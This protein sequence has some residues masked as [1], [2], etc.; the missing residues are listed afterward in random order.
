VSLLGPAEKGYRYVLSDRI[1]KSNVEYLDKSWD[2]AIIVFATLSG[3][4]AMLHVIEGSTVDISPFGVGGSI[5]LG[6]IVEPVL[7]VVD[8][9]WT[10]TFI[11]ASTL[12]VSKYLLILGH[13][14][15]YWLL[16]IF[17]LLFVIWLIIRQ[18]HRGKIER[19]AKGICSF[20][21]L[22][23]LTLSLFLPLAVS[24]G[25]WLST[26]VTAKLHENS[27]KKIEQMKKE[28]E[29]IAGISSQSESAKKKESKDK[30]LSFSSLMDKIKSSLLSF[31]TDAARI[32]KLFEIQLSMMNDYIISLIVVFILDCYV[33]PLTLFAC[34]YFLGRRVLRELF[35]VLDNP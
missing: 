27:V 7:D 34:F 14:A 22:I 28:L 32:Y 10:A 11:S 9:G 2:K 21:L 4:K 20:L 17:L 8:F 31:K 15:E 23:Y 24:G 1:Y 33:L 29:L 13:S 19:V 30:G 16:Q 6:D 26:K 25:Q 18:V 35:P 5:E 3:I 12:M